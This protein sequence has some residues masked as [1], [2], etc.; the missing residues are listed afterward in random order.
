MPQI[1]HSSVTETVWPWRDRE[2][3]KACALARR[4]QHRLL[5]QVTIALA[6][7][8]LML[9]LNFRRTGT[10]A[11]CVGTVIFII[12]ILV[13]RLYDA[14]DRA[15]MLAARAVGQVLTWVMLVP[16]FYLC[17]LPGRLILMARGKDPMLRKCPSG[18]ATYWVP[19][20]PRRPDHFAR[21]Y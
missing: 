10:I 12:G 18:E 7:G 20:P 3:K 2:Q 6:A 14:I 9:I 5:L 19:R 1:E 11:I 8:A 15:V 17:F 4:R 21:Q 16:F 13:P